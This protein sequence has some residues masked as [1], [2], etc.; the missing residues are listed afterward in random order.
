MAD[1]SNWRTEADRNV[2]PKKMSTKQTAPPHPTGGWQ[3][4]DE[5]DQI[6]PDQI[7]GF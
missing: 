3:P 1:G 5:P 2:Q 4:A 7:P 6:R